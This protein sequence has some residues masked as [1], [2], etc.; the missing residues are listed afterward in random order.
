MAPQLSYPLDVG[1][2]VDD[3]G[4][5]E[6]FAGLDAS[7]ISECDLEMVFQPPCICDLDVA[8]FRTG[9]RRELLASNST[10]LGGSFSISREKAVDAL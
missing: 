8:S 6:E 10:Q 5:Q 3:T 4:S 7:A 9:V 1:Q 2:F